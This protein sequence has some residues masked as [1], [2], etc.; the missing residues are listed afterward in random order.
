M[1]L[2]LVQLGDLAEQLKH[3]SVVYPAVSQ[4]IEL[5]YEL[6]PVRQDRK[7]FSLTGDGV[8]FKFTP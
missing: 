8:D 1:S 4:R 5:V 3:R 2:F 6:Q 7:Q